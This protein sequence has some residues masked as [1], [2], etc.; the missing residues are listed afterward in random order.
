[1]TFATKLTSQ[2]VEKLRTLVG[3]VCVHRTIG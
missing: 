1:M 3:T 2:L